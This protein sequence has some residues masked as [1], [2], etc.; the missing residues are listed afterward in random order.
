VWQVAYHH[1]HGFF[2]YGVE[3]V[4]G[5]VVGSNWDLTDLKSAMAL[6]MTLVPFLVLRNSN[7]SLTTLYSCFCNWIRLVRIIGG[8]IP[9]SAG[10]TS[11]FELASRKSRC[12][13]PLPWGGRKISA[14]DFLEGDV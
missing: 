14:D 10:S 13:R 2:G 8:G 11:S 5:Q 12:P 6:V 1:F 9:V 4:M 7:F 3:R